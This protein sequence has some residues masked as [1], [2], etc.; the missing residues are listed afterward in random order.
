MNKKKIIRLSKKIVS[1]FGADNI[2][3]ILFHG[4]ILFNPHIPPHDADLIIVLKRQDAEDCSNLRKMVKQYTFQ[5]RNL[6]FALGRRTENELLWARKKSVVMLKDLLLSTGILLQKEESI[7]SKSLEVFKDFSEDE[8]DFLKALQKPWI[9]PASEKLERVF[10]TQCL[11]VHE[12]AYGTM[13][14]RIADKHHCRF[15]G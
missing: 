3:C 12:R 5:M 6:V 15:L 2:V 11:Q 1:A 14:K 10:M 7:I 9:K 13:R 8:V 4:S